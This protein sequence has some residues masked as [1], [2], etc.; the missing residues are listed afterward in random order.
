MTQIYNRS[1]QEGYF[2]F[3]RTFAILSVLYFGGAL[4]GAIL[5]PWWVPLVFEDAFTPAVPTIALLLF[6]V[7]FSVTGRIVGILYL[8]PAKMEKVYQ[9]MTLLACVAG[10]A[11]AIPAAIYGS[12]TVVVLRL[13]VEIAIF[14]GCIF[15]FRRLRKSEV[16]EYSAGN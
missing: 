16:S 7:P 6:A 15:I 11:L 14:A 9:R 8:V 12:M 3:R 1:K 2:W 5:A 13:A 10:A 4:F